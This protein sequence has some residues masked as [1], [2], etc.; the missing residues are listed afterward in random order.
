[1]NQKKVKAIEIEKLNKFSQPREVFPLYIQFESGAWR[2]K[3]GTREERHNTGIEEIKILDFKGDENEKVNHAKKT[4]L[5]TSAQ[6]IFKSIQNSIKQ[7]RKERIKKSNRIK[8][9]YR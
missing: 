5:Y 9:I 1:M 2:I 8:S 3:K 7:K 4:K 6:W